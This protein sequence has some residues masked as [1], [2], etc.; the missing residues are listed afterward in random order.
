MAPHRPG[1]RGP[2]ETGKISDAAHDIVDGG[3][4]PVLKR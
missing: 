1:I 3:Y 2:L 4:N